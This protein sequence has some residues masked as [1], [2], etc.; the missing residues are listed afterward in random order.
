MGNFI[1][2]E[3][4]AINYPGN[5]GKKKFKPKHIKINAKA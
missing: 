2:Q 4:E 1:F 3:K 5:H